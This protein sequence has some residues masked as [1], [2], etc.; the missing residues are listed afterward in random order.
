MVEKAQ[1]M[2]G[3]CLC[4]AIRYSAGERLSGGMVCHCRMCQR[5]SGSAFS[6]NAIY[7]LDS[8]VI[9]QGEPSWFTSSEIAERGFCAQCGS[10]LFMRYSVSEWRGWIAVAVASHDRPEEIP[11]ERHFGIESEMSWLHDSDKLPRST[12][13]EGFMANVAVDGNA[14]YA[15]LP[16]RS[17]G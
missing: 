15:T 16:R 14:A 10:P 7:V 4:G 13:P 3:G 8:L 2:V 5:A 12:Y 9:T 17:T 6:Y 11:A 1:T